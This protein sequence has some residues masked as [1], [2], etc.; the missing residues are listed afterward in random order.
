MLIRS[1]VAGTSL[2][3]LATFSAAGTDIIASGQNNGDPSH[4]SGNYYY[5]INTSTGVATP[6]SPLL[7]GSA[8]SGLAGTADGRLLGFQSGRVG[9]I[10]PVAG[11]FTPIGTSNGLSITGFEVIGDFGYGVPT[12]GADRRLHRIDLTT[13]EAT[14]IGIPGVIAGA[15]DTFFGVAPGVTSPFIIGLGSVSGTLY[16]VH[17]GTA[18]NNLVAIDPTTGAATPI[19]VVNAVG[20]SG[21]TGVGSF[22]GFSAMTGVDEDGNG[23][24]DALFGNVNFVDPDA[25]GPIPSQRLGGV[26]RY[27]IATGTWSMVGTNPGI[28]FFGFGSVGRTGLGQCSIGDIA[29]GGPSGLLPDGILDGSDFVAFINSFSIGDSAIDDLADIAPP[30]GDAIIDGNDFIVFINAFAAG[31]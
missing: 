7:S 10:D 25:S 24:N 15:L 6:I 1:F 21:G 4:S 8:P 29:G 16:G 12:S 23:V 2:I 26:A 11:T 28:I 14:P 5:R 18:R 31:C 27:D 20:T 9:E 22:A 19:G 13:S 30:G 3:A 17:V